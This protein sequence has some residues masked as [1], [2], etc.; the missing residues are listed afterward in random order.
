MAGPGRDLRSLLETI[1]V[2]LTVARCL[3][4]HRRP[5]NVDLQPVI[6]QV[7]R[8]SRWMMQQVNGG[9][10]E[11]AVRGRGETNE[12]TTPVT[13]P[14][15]SS[16]SDSNHPSR[17]VTDV[18]ASASDGSKKRSHA[19]AAKTVAKKQKTEQSSGRWPGTS[20]SRSDAST[21]CVKTEAE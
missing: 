5:V 19:S 16:G 15:S 4:D 1:D 7:L 20:K 12:A 18:V 14:V 3:C 17:T 13:T 6:D 10:V 2:I 21:D 9:L 11:V 8:Q